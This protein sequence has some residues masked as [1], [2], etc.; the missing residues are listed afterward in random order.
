MDGWW[1]DLSRL[2]KI[3]WSD[4]SFISITKR[5]LFDGLEVRPSS[6]WNKSNPTNLTF[7]AVVLLP[8]ISLALYYMYHNFRLPLWTGADKR[9]WKSHNHQGDRIPYS[10]FPFSFYLFIYHTTYAHIFNKKIYILL[11]LGRFT[12][13]LPIYHHSNSLNFCKIEGFLHGRGFPSFLLH[14]NHK[15]TIRSFHVILVYFQLCHF[16]A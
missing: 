14:H 6:P 7:W 2:Q 11:S 15:E 10:F 8:S 9:K 12:G 1:K 13:L 5:H 16:P 3:I 4:C